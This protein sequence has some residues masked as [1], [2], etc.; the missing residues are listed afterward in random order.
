MDMEQHSIRNLCSIGEAAK[1]T[2]L[3]VKS[4]LHYEEAGLTPRPHR[5]DAKAR[6]GSNRLYAEQ[7]LYRLRFIRQARHLDAGLGE[8]RRI[9]QIAEET[10]PSR[11]LDYR[12]ILTGHLETVTCRID[13]LSDLRAQLTTVLSKD[14]PEPARRCSGD[15]CGCLETAPAS[16]RKR[17]VGKAEGRRSRQRKRREPAQP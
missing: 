11:Y 10:Y 14:E 16:N 9:L 2:S 3:S 17:F 13:Q 5:H 15:G 6:T 8:I 1:A 4:M 12:R 7:D